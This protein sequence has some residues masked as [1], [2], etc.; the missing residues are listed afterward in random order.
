MGLFDLPVADHWAWLI[1]GALMVTA[2]MLAPGFF[3]M[4]IGGAA[5]LVGLATAVLPIGAELQLILFAVIA[6]AAVYAARR[7]F[8]TNAIQ[9]ADPDLNNRGARLTGEVVTVVEALDGGRGR[10]KVGDSVW[11]A[12]GANAPIGAKLRVT[13]CDGSVLLVDPA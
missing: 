1:L 3:L 11:T 8:V 10:V 4:W 9:S 12:K 5:L 2:E 6:P 7:W 13:G